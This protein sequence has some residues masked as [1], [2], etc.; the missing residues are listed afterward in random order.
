[1]LSPKKGIHKEGHCIGEEPTTTRNVLSPLEIV[2]HQLKP[3]NLLKHQALWSAELAET[4]E[5][6]EEA[7]L[8]LKK[9]GAQDTD[10]Q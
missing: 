1:M 4:A 9:S 7:D 6:A 10:T 5:L 2:E 8:A 3:L